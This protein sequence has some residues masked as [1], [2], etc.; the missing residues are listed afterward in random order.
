MKKM[1][2]VTVLRRARK[3]IE[4]GWCKDW[5]AEDKKGNYALPYSKA[6]VK[7]CAYGAISAFQCAVA[8]ERDARSLLDAVVPG[9]DIVTFNDGQKSKR[10]VLAAFDR[11]IAL[12]E[13]RDE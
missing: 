9:R 7:W 8:T 4:K 1:K 6:A 2:P 3:L 11:A 13:A 12:A 5:S 10:P